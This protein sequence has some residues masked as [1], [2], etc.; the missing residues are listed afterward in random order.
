MKRNDIK[1]LKLANNR[2][3]IVT[4]LGV[5]AC[6]FISILT[7]SAYIL[8]NSETKS[9]KLY[10]RFRDRKTV[11]SHIKNH[12]HNNLRKQDPN[13][14]IAQSVDSLNTIN[15]D[16]CDTTDGS[17][18][19]MTSACSHVLVGQKLFVCDLGQTAVFMS[20]I[21]DYVCDCRDGSDE[22]GTVSCE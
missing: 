7:I 17:D 13:K 12:Q 2:L 15:D 18:E 3:V 9:N 5:I 16:Y 4:V 22:E 19:M 11:M 6:F 20:R 8:Q 10:L 14:A 1:S 21:N